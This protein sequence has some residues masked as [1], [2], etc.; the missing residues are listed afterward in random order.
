[1]FVGYWLAGGFSK[2]AHLAQFEGGPKTP[3]ESETEQREGERSAKPT[4]R[5]EF[6][7]KC[8]GIED[9]DSITV[10]T[11]GKRQRKIRLDGIDAPEKG[12]EFSD[13]AKAK[14]SSLV[15]EKDLRVEVTGT[16]FFGRTLAIVWVGDLNVNL[17]MVRSG[18]AWHFVKYSKDSTLSAAQEEASARKAGLWAGFNPL[19]PWSYRELKKRGN[20]QPLPL[21]SD[22]T[23]LKNDALPRTGSKPEIGGEYW[24]NLGTGERH[25]S[26]CRWFLR[27]KG[28]RFCSA[29]EGDP[30]AICGG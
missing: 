2:P 28:G 22:E 26:T 25:N 29:I 13:K 11:P 24:L 23:Q 5:E 15:F 8:V 30:C 10:L 14:L 9:G 19:A 7:G 4:E 27:T 3:R 12:Q 21:V 1:M 20:A 18:F 17:E 16:D 6:I